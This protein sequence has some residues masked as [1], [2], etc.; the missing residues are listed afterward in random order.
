MVTLSNYIEHAVEIQ[1]RVA[2][3]VE[4][5]PLMQNYAMISIIKYNNT[6]LEI[7][8]DPSYLPTHGS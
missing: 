7:T 5:V 1:I 4:C 8:H 2:A 3:H 6:T